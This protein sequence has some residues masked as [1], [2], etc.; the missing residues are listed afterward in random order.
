MHCGGMTAL[1]VVVSCAWMTCSFFREITTP[2]GAFCMSLGTAQLLFHAIIK[3]EIGELTMNFDAQTLEFTHIIHLLQQQAVSPAARAQLA[4]LS[5]STEEDVCRARM[6]ETTSARDVLEKLGNPPL[7]MMEDLAAHLDIAMQGGMLMP[8][9]L[10]DIVRFAVSVRS[11]RRYLENCATVNPAMASWRIELPALD[12]LE[13]IIDAC[14]REDA[15]LDTASPTLRSLRRQQESIT[16]EI[17]EKLDRILSNRK[18]YLADAYITQRAGRYVLP[19]QRKW[20]NSFGGTVVDASAKGGTVFMEPTSIAPLRMEKEAL[21]MAID[22][23]ERHILYQLS[24]EVAD[25]EALLHKASRTMAAL[26][27]LFAKAKLSACMHARPV[28]LT[29]S[30]RLILRHAQHPLLA[31]EGRVP[32]DF[33]LEDD[34]C[35]VAITGPNTGGKTVAI[36]TVGLLCMMAQCGLHLP[37]DEG[38]VIGLCDG[39]FCDI[40]D[41]QSIAQNLSTFSGHMTRIIQ[42]LS[43]ASRDS[44]VLLDE[45]GSGTDPAEGS[46]IAIAVLEELLHRNCRFLVTT[47]DPQVKQ[48]A[49][50]AKGVV[51]AR[52]AFDRQSLSPLYRLEMGVAGESCALEIVRRLGLHKS[53]LLRATQAAQGAIAP[54]ERSSSGMPIP[55]SRLRRSQPAQAASEPRFA[56][57]DS[58]ELLPEGIIAI[59]YQPENDSGYVVVQYR[60]EKHTVRHTRLKLRVPAS[61]LYPPDYDFSILFES[62]EN[63]KADHAM[64]RKFVPGLKRNITP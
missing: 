54:M 7:A 19:V 14:I 24:G 40:G 35:G 18:Q 48:W 2:F 10:S 53:L 59:V 27:A 29:A 13:E 36:K 55:P 43:H 20:Q 5:P 52:M 56:I 39:I 12:N 17:R 6:K 57:G 9:Q 51:P 26:D 60:G 23:E 37:C 41:N 4:A 30:R 11:L 63:R 34:G 44:L 3:R 46:G 1:F 58:V 31:E 61:A 50:Q 28:A 42:M 62:V 21:E 33:T 64:S 38:T 49:V 45:L 16:Q 15:I 47:H 22:E 8:K 32:L 25:R